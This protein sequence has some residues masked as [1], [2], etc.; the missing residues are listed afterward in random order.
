MKHIDEFK[1][2]NNAK[3]KIKIVHWW[4]IGITIMCI[5]SIVFELVVL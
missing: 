5:F 3:G 4:F 2:A 1:K